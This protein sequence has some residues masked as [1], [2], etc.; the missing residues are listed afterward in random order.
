MDA[1]AFFD[2]VT[3]NWKTQTMCFSTVA[4]FGAGVILSGAGILAVRKVTE[5]KQRMFA[6]IPAV[7]AIQ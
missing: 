4:S 1:A 5:P 3:H 2:L 7:F 6:A